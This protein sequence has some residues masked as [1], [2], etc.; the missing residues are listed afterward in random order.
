L[1]GVIIASFDHRHRD[2]C[3]YHA[4]IINVKVSIKNIQYVLHLK[5]SQSIPL[6]CV[7]DQCG[8]ILVLQMHQ[9]NIYMIYIVVFADL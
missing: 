5:R 6:S 1:S 9:Q 8:G 7:T 4:K 3:S 2:T